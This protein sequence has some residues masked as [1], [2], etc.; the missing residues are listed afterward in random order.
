MKKF[1]RHLLLVVT[2]LC[3]FLG[4]ETGIRAQEFISPDGQESEK[5]I[6]QNS[7]YLLPVDDGPQLPVGVA[8]YS[9][10]SSHRIASS[11]PTRLLPTHGGKSGKYNGRWISD[12]LCK[13]S[14]SFSF[15]WSCHLN[16]L[17]TIVAP[18]RHYYVIALRRLL[19]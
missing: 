15:Q 7:D 11:R 4:S 17:N 12:D 9:P 1:L 19:C 18:P 2:V 3:T 8:F 13:L 14:K 5:Q 10:P 16:R 6:R